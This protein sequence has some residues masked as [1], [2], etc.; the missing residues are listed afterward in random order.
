MRKPRIRV[1]Q[2]TQRRLSRNIDTQ[3]CYGDEIHGREPI[4]RNF[5]L[6]ATSKPFES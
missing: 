1:T 2:N 3:C 4:G 5:L 6:F